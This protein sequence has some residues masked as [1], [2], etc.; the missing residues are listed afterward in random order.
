[1]DNITRAICRVYNFV[2]KNICSG[3]S[4]TMLMF[5]VCTTWTATLLFLM[6]SA[7]F[8]CVWTTV[9]IQCV[10]PVTVFEDTF[11]FVSIPERDETYFWQ[12]KT[13]FVA[14]VLEVEMKQIPAVLPS[15]EEVDDVVWLHYYNTVCV[16]LSICLALAYLPLFS[17][18]VRL[19]NDRFLGNKF[20]VCNEEKL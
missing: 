14:K 17:M 18:K 11:K 13:F 2:E 20:Y 10:L 4:I 19:C 8:V 9:G 1:M 7:T 3:D 15:G 12:H 5:K 6:L 16:L